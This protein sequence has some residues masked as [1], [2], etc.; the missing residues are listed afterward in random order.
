MGKVH[1]LGAG[2]SGERPASCPD[3]LVFRGRAGDGAECHVTFD[4]SNIVMSRPLGGLACKIRMSLRH[5]Q[6]IAVVVGEE[7]CTVRLMHREPG[8]CVDLVAFDDFAA[9]EDHRDRLADFLKLPPL[10][11]AG[12]AAFPGE[13]APEAVPTPRRTK[14]SRLRRARFLTRRQPGEVIAIRKIDG[15]ELIART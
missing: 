1:T 8:L 12:R 9:A 11:L 7:R 5:Y 2:R 10:T 4:R 6:S 14:P 3:I 15:Q 13:R